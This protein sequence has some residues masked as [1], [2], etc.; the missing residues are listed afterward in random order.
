MRAR[1]NIRFQGTGAG[2]TELVTTKQVDYVS[3]G[4][5]LPFSAEKSSANALL[6]SFCEPSPVLFG[7]SIVNFSGSFASRAVNSRAKGL[8]LFSGSVTF[9]TWL[10]WPAIASFHFILGN[11][12]FTAIRTSINH[13]YRVSLIF[14]RYKQGT[15]PCHFAPFTRI[16]SR[17]SAC[18]APTGD[19]IQKLLWH[20]FSH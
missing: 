4:E 16:I 20:I 15:V 3:E 11:I 6:F 17:H 1:A 19:M 7:I 10:G 9:P 14:Y 2:D 8:N 12:Y 18:K 13:K 5:S